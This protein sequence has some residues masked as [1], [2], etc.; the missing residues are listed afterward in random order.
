ML[1][2]PLDPRVSLDNVPVSR[3]DQPDP[4][5]DQPSRVEYLDIAATL[6]ALVDMELAGVEARA[7]GTLI[8]PSD[9]DKTLR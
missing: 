5:S 4:I 8:A 6:P 9:F 2:R 3:D 1:T 7:I